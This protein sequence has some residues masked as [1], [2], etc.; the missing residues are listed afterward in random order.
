MQ[1]ASSVS[2][3]R[4]LPFFGLSHSI[5]GDFKTSLIAPFKT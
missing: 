5:I 3:T 4:T 1:E 2:H